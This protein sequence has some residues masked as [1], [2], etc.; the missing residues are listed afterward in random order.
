MKI[1]NLSILFLLA[2]ALFCYSPASFAQGTALDEALTK[3]ISAVA[4]PEPSAAP[5]APSVSESATRL[6]IFKYLEAGEGRSRSR[7]LVGA[8]LL[9]QF[10][11]PSTRGQA[12]VGSCHA[13]GSVAVLE[14]AYFRAHGSKVQLSEADIFIRRTVLSKDWY[15]D[16]CSGGACK[17]SEGND[18]LGDLEYAKANGVATSVGYDRFLE[19]YRKFRAAE[20]RT[21]EGIDAEEKRMG[22]L[23]RMLY[24]P[25]AHWAQLQEG[26]SSKRISQMLLLGQD[27][28]IDTERATIKE[29]LK[30]FVIEQKTFPYLGSDVHALSAA[31]RLE[32]GE[33][34]RSFILRELSAGRPVALSMSLSN[35][36]GW[37]QTDT[38]E[39]ANH[40]FM[41]IGFSR[42]ADSR[43]V[44]HTR[45]SWAGVNPD[46]KE[47]ELCRIFSA[48]TVKVPG[49]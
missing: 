37:G 30:D 15:R 31:D 13:F 23:Q 24:D 28:R 46:I 21:L 18:V 25:K 40:A 20:Q 49:E 5:A 16:F 29:K 9:T 45:N 41:I 12:N 44:F 17:V 2:G 35:L 11:D 27:P 19:R 48:I 26:E 47:D 38:S 10:A 8:S 32:K 43:P 4:V 7:T 1:K 6:G 33:A 3:G 42:G 36:A 39:H 34:Q 22:W 14:A